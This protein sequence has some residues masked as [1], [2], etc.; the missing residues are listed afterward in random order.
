MTLRVAV[1]LAFL[2]SAEAAGAFCIKKCD[3][4]K[5]RWPGNDVTFQLGNQSFSNAGYLN[6]IYAA[7]DAWNQ[8]PAFFTF[9]MSY[10][11]YSVG[12]DNDT[13]EIWF[14]TDQ[15]IL[16]GAPG[17]T[18][19]WRD[20]E[21]IE[22]TDIVFDANWSYT[23]GTTKSSSSAYG[24]PY[25]TFRTAAA[26]E[27]GHSLGLC[28]NRYSYNIMGDDSTVIN[29]NGSTLRPYAG[30]SGIAGELYLYDVWPPSTYEDVS[31]VHWKY[32]GN[33]GEY[34]THVRTQIYDTSDN[35]LGTVGCGANNAEPCYKVSKGQT[36]KVEF[37]YENLGRHTQNVDIGYYLSTND[38]I[39]TADTFLFQGNIPALSRPIVT[40]NNT[41]VTIPNNLVSGQNYYI[42]AIVNYNKKFAEYTASNNATYIGIRIK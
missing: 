40:T 14:S 35:P 28:H 30:A 4:T 21:E 10:P 42:G 18:L 29:A 34:S 3:G 38:L 5:V 19:T 41:Y 1:G 13:N 25:R 6:A 26:H 16:D 2:L 12:Q 33:D 17:T 27:L 9:H 37:T 32:G 23:T 36:V 24:G 11:T 15:D 7:R 22:E 8:S 39:T 20:C 31:V